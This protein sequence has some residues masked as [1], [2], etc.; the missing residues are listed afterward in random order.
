MPRLSLDAQ[1]AKIKRQKAALEKRK[2]ITENMSPEQ[3]RGGE[4]I[5]FRSDMFSLGGVLYHLLTGA[6]PF[7]GSTAFEL[8]EAILQLEPPP[9]SELRQGLPPEFDAI[10]RRALGKNRSGR[11]AVGRGTLLRTSLQ[12]YA[13]PA[14]RRWRS[15]A[16]PR[17]A[18]WLRSHAAAWTLS[19]L[20]KART[21]ATPRR[22]SLG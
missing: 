12:F 2:K 16:W 4:E 9:P 8:M 20:A 1:L 5:D 14:P 15:T 22:K 17:A 13:L 6:R 19:S 21:G 7:G 18:K 11:C 10:V 3:I